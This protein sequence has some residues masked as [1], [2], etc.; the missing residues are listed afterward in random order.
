MLAG[1][2]K[3]FLYLPALFQLPKCNINMSLGYDDLHLKTN[4]EL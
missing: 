1:T 3:R 4:F 2:P